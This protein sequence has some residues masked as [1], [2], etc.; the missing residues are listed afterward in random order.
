MT[1]GPSITVLLRAEKTGSKEPTSQ[2]TWTLLKSTI[3]SWRTTSKMGMV[4]GRGEE[5]RE[6]GRGVGIE[7]DGGRQSI[8][9]SLICFCLVLNVDACIMKLVRT[10]C[11]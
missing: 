5:G 6:E 7:K 4:K 9:V 2:T 3:T 8:K 1:G 11:M 10:T